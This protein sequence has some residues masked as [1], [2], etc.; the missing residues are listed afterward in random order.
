MSLER[1]LMRSLQERN[2]AS[3]IKSSGKD[4]RSASPQSP[5][6]LQRGIF[7]E[8]KAAEYLERI[9]YKIIARNVNCR[10]GEIDIIA[11]DGD[12]IVFV[13]VRARSKGWM[14]PPECTVGPEKLKKLKRAARI[15]T[16]SRNY[17]GFW[18][19]DLIAVT[20]DDDKISSLEH[21]KEITEGII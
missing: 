4:L 14:M 11:C 2:K 13:E 21:I 6:H 3:A 17:T 1:A 8:E 20:L 16:E 9:G 10:H 15:W 18:R 19:I 7:G 5:L 12:E